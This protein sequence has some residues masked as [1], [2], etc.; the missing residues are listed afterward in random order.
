MHPGVTGVLLSP[1]APAPSPLQAE[2]ERE[3]IDWSYISFIDNQDVLDLIEGKLGVLDLLDEQCRSG[4][5]EGC[6]T[7]R[8]SD[9]SSVCPAF[10]RM[11]LSRGSTAVCDAHA[12][13]AVHARAP[14]PGRFPTATHKDLAEKLYGSELCKTSQRFTRP[15]TSQTAF[16]LEHYAGPVRTP[17]S[18]C[19]SS[20]LPAPFLRLV[21]LM[22]NPVR[23]RRRRRNP[24]QQRC[25]A[26]CTDGARGRA[27]PSSARARC[28]PVQ[29]TYQCD[30]FLD[31]NKDFVVAEHQSLLQA[32]SQE[33]LATLFPPPP[34][35]VGVPAGCV[36]QRR[37]AGIPAQPTSSRHRPITPRARAQSGCRLPLLCAP[38]CLT[39]L[40]CA[41]CWPPTRV[42]GEITGASQRQARPRPRRRLVVQI[43]QRGQPVQAPA[44]GAHDAAQ[45]H[46]APLCQVG[47]MWDD[48]F[49]CLLLFCV[50]SSQEPT[51]WTHACC[52]PRRCIKPNSLNKPG[53]FENT[54]AL[55]QLK[56]GGVMEAVRISCA[57]FPNKRIFFDFVEHFWPLAPDTYHDDDVSD[58]D[59]AETILKKS[60]IAGYQ[61]GKTKVGVVVEACIAAPPAPSPP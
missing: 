24:R 15:K 52:T 49:H 44:R 25:W 47:A 23:Q 43:Q 4:P 60:G 26:Q 61:L 42:A 1:G 33:F 17:C 37:P 34:P 53:I 48:G 51:G 46:G 10:M 8:P 27:F 9:R 22:M 28:R 57:G 21:M 54:N 19:H 56:C 32:S 11:P 39:A 38:A 29:V 50:E 59:I 18:T 41:C 16:T 3:A 13:A 58:R 12:R 35:E 40:S 45:P 55:H 7:C 36:W 14:P 30:N 20:S 5:Q 31:K 2:Y 6:C